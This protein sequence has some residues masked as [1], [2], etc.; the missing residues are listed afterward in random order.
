MKKHILILSSVSALML[1]S[2]FTVLQNTGIA[3]YTGSPG[4]ATCGGVGGCHGNTGGSNTLIQSTPAF[5]A[6]K[7]VPGTTYTIEI[8]VANGNLQHF[9]FGCEILNASNTN[10]GIMQNPIANTKFLNAGNGRKN[11][12]HNGVFAAGTTSGSFKFE[13]VAPASGNVTIYA[14]GNTS[15]NN[16]SSSGDLVSNATL[17]LSPSGA[18][19]I[20]ENLPVSALTIAQNAALNSITMSYFKSTNEALTFGLVDINGKEIKEV[21]LANQELGMIENTV[22]IGN[23]ESG[24]YFATLKS[25]TSVVAKKLVMLK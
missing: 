19:N 21:S 1:G 23:L 10:A 9:G 13:W 25:N 5:V 15:N 16:N 11:A 3:G 17:S 12:V 18:T 22:S 7:Y 20:K 2:A 8:K 6:N 4:E 24:V 14:A